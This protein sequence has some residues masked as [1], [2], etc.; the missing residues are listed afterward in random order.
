MYRKTFQ[1]LP[2]VL[3]LTIS[4]TYVFAQATGGSIT[5]TVL[6]VNGAAVAN[7]S[8]TLNNKATGQILTT[9]TTEAGAYSFPNVPVGEY[10]M[11]I[12]SAGFQTATQDVRIVLNQES[13]VN[14]TLQAAG[15]AGGVVE[16]TASSEALVQTDSSQLARSYETR[17][18]QDL[19]IFNDPRTL[20]LLAP[21]VVAQASGVSGD[22][23]SVG[24]TRPRANTFNVDGVDNND[25]SIT[26]RD[27]EIIQDAISEVSLLTNNYNAEY[28]TGAAGVF[29]IVTRSGTNEFHGS[30]FAY[31]QNQRLNAASTT[32]EFL[33]RNGD[34]TEI[35]QTRDVRYGVTLGG[36]IIRN[37][38]FFFGAL[39]RNP[40]SG[41]G[42]GVTYTA[43]T[44]EG[45]ERIAAL[46][47]ASP[48][49][50]GLLRNNLF[51][52]SNATT[53]LNV[54]GTPI[55]FGDASVV[56]PG[57]SQQNQYQLNI[58]HLLG[59]RDQFRYRYSQDF[60]TTLEP[61]NGNPQFAN[62]VLLKN[63]LFSTTWVRTFNPSTV[64]ELRL[65]YKRVLDDRPLL[66][67]RFNDFPNITVTPLNLA[68][69][70]NGD[71]PQGGFNNGY[72]IYDAVNYVRG[73][74]N[75]KLGGEVRFLIFTSF[76][77]PRGRG[78]YIY[79]TFD[80]LIQD[81]VPQPAATNALRGV[82]ASGF[83]G[84]QKKFYLFG[85]DDWKV[86]PNLT[87]NLGLRYE[88][89]TIPRDAN[90]QE[91]N[92][93]SSVPGIIDFRRLR[94]DKNNFSPRIGLAYSPE[95]GSG[96]RR[97]LFGERG[98]S[99]IRAGFALTYYETFQ[100]IY[101]LQLPPQFQQELDAET[102]G[103]G[104]PFLQNGGVPPMPIPPN[105]VAAARAA[106]GA[107]TRDPTEPYIMS[108]TL[109][110]QRQL[111][112]TTALEVRYLGTR[113]RHLPIQLRLTGGRVDYNR[114]VVPT[115]LTPPTTTQLAGLPTIAQ[116]G[117][118]KLFPRQLGEFGFQSNIT[119]FEPSGNSQYDAGS[120]SLTRRFSRGLAMTAA[121]TFSKAID[122][123]TNELNS[124]T[125]NPRRPEDFFD[126]NERGLSAIDV[127]HRFV[128][129]FNYELPFF[130]TS[131]NGFLRHV[132]GGYSLNGIF[133]AQSGQVITP[134][135]GIDSNRNRDAAGDRTIVNPNGVP[136]TGSGVIALNR[137]GQEVELGD[138][139]TVAY[140]ALNA[141]AQYIQ[142][143]FGARTNA[144]RNTL[145]T[146]G[147]NRTDM[148]IMKNFRFGE[149][150][151]NLQVGAEVFNIFN[152][153]I[154][155][156]G[157]FGSPNFSAQNFDDTAGIGPRTP[158]FANVASANF[159]DYSIGNFSGRTVQLRA[160]FI[161]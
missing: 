117:V 6:D 78:D 53:T 41:A 17:Q 112:P 21:N 66:N 54:L 77:L 151:Y 105:T 144:G 160:K 138:D 42:A 159:N 39:Q 22:G 51:L 45:L 82:G 154:R 46:P 49:V 126:L 98:Q 70:P 10:G 157:D 108:F 26:G 140:V 136:G 110:Y 44:A 88:Y 107:L 155:T 43:P 148:V 5:G 13:S 27:V 133:Q 153:R 81:R 52:P 83:T 89:L 129:S 58:D 142:A 19:P 64:N 34:I 15:V 96:F 137:S 134:Q 69:G 141:N 139:A 24:G 16:V 106:T 161:F 135:S 36:P 20:S 92:S 74:H 56:T 63:R 95:G 31:L 35:P 4:T 67:E 152:Q 97:F 87:L 23:G 132:L 1:I 50:V 158:A 79:S 115:F 116:L 121:Y 122:D 14:A 37:K 90:L 29:N 104:A 93:I 7:A 3:L 86:T 109:S 75:V 61:G 18:V 68:L 130:R 40:I 28:G 30:G 60:S 123:A 48:F 113:G 65:S 128:T 120:V 76:F 131:G 103:V 12:A 101:L 57:G 47:G 80:E 102:A 59:T 149:E 55:P 73:A 145:R 99:A 111:T 91:L 143:G 150:R 2:V 71:L 32:E 72:Q 147:F 125:V 119:F 11:N 25:P 8:V 62:Q 124:S 85:Q 156:I 118:S 127:P 38:L 114:L 94:S 100:N 84:N 9:Q 146:N 33:I